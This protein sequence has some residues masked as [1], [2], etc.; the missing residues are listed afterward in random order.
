MSVV[1]NWYDFVLQQMA[2]ESYFEDV[3]LSDPIDIR[4][5]LTFGNNRQGFPFN[6]N[7]RFTDSQ[8]DD[9][10]D[11]FQIIHQ[12]SD[13]PNGTSFFDNTGLSAT[14]IFNKETNEYT[15]SIRSTEYQNK[16]LG[17]DFERDVL[18]GADRE[19]SNVG[20][21][22]AQLDSL[23]HYY[24]WLKESGKL[25]QG[26]VLNVTGYSL[27]GHLATVF[28]EVHS[29]EIKHTYL[30]NA[31]GRGE[32]RDPGSLNDGYTPSARLAVQIYHDVL[33]DPNAWTRYFKEGTFDFNE[34]LYQNARN[35][36]PVSTWTVTQQLGDGYIYANNRHLW[37]EKVASQLTSQLAIGSLDPAAN[38]KITDLYGHAAHND[39]EWVAT[40]GVRATE[41]R[42]QKI[43]IEDQQDFTGLGGFFGL[44]GDFGNTH[45]ITLVADS[46][47]VM[48]LLD[49][50]GLSTETATDRENAYQL[51]AA[52]SNQLG[53]GTL[54]LGDGKAEG[55][56]LEKIVESLYK[57]FKNETL[58]LRVDRGDR[59]FANIE[60]RNKFYEAIDTISA[61]A[62]TPLRYQFSSLAGTPADV[63]AAVAKT[64]NALATRYALKEGNPFIISGDDSL[65][66]SHNLNGELELYNPGS[67]TGT[68][69]DEYINERARFLERKLYYNLGDAR[70]NLMAGAPQRDDQ[71][72]R[73]DNEDI[74]WKDS[75]SGITINRGT[76]GSSRYVLF[77]SDQPDSLTGGARDDYLF[78]GAGND[79]LHGGQGD[80][81][82][83]GGSGFDIYGFHPGDGNDTLL[84]QDGKG[85]LRYGPSG[86]E[87]TLV[88][89][90]RNSSDPEGQY[91]SADGLTSYVINSTNL[92][93]TTPDGG[94]ITVR[95]FDR[96]KTDLG[97]H[98]FDVPA[99]AIGSVLEGT[100]GNNTTSSSGD[101]TPYEPG[102]NQ[103]NDSVG[104]LIASADTAAIDGLG[105][106]DTLIGNNLPGDRLNGGDGHDIIVDGDQPSGPGGKLYG[107]AGN[108]ILFANG[109]DDYIDGGA[110]NDFAT[111]NAGS[112]L[113]LGDRGADWLDG[114]DG[115]DAQE[116]GNDNDHLL[117]GAGDDLLQGEGGDDT[118]Y[119]DTDF[120]AIFLTR[121][122]GVIGV[123]SS[124]DPNFSGIFPLLRDVTPSAAGDDVLDGGAGNDQLYAGAGDDV[125][126]GGADND[127]LEGEGG[128]D[129]LLG[130]A[131]EDILW[132]DADPDT[133]VTD[134]AISITAGYYRYYTRERNVG[135]DGN[136]TLAGGGGNDRLFGGGGDDTY[137]FG[138]GDGQ[139]IIL[140]ATG[141][142][143]LR[144]DVGS[145]DVTLSPSGADLI[146]S[147]NGTSDSVTLRNWFGAS[148]NRIESL[149][150]A[151]GTMW[152][153]SVVERLTRTKPINGPGPVADD[154][155]D[156]TTYAA[157]LGADLTNGFAI[158]VDDAGGTDALQFNRLFLGSTPAGPL[159]VT[160]KLQSVV[161][162]GSDLLINLLLQPPSGSTISGSVRIENYSGAGEIESI[163]IADQQLLSLHSAAVT[164]G[165]YLQTNQVSP[166]Y[167]RFDPNQSYAGIRAEIVSGTD[168]D[169][170]ASRYGLTSTA[171]D[172]HSLGSLGPF[173][174][175]ILYG[176]SGNDVLVGADASDT[177]VGG[178]G[179][180]ILQGGRGSDNYYVDLAEQDVVFDDNLGNSQVSLDALYLPTGV[181]LSD[182]TFSRTGDDLL[183][184][185]LRIERY[186]DRDFA[187]LGFDDYPFQIERLVGDGWQIADLPNYLQSLG[188]Y[189][190]I[191]GAEAGDT[192]RGDNLNNTIDGGGGDDTILGGK[193]SDRLS[194]GTG[195]DTLYGEAIYRGTASSNNDVLDG[196]EGDDY[197]E[198]DERDDTLLGGAGDDVL[199]GDVVLNGNP[200][201]FGTPGRDVLVGGRGNDF[202]YGQQDGDIYR[203]E[204]GDGADVLFDSGINRWDNRSGNSS[205]AVTGD[206]ISELTS[207]IDALAD[208]SDGRYVSQEWYGFALEYDLDELLPRSILDGLF[209]QLPADLKENGQI[210]GVS[211]GEALA[212]LSELRDWLIRDQEDVVEFGAGISIED[213]VVASTFDGLQI[214][215]AEGD[216]VTIEDAE[217][218]GNLGIERFR[219]SDGTTLALDDVL[220][221]V[222]TPVSI[223]G[224]EGDDEL[225]GNEA[226]NVLEGR[227]GDDILY[228]RSGD[229]I[230][231]GGTGTAIGD[232]LLGEEGSDV[233]LFNR[234]DIISNTDILAQYNV[235]N[236]S[237]FNP[238]PM[239]TDTDIDT[240][241]FGA[242][243]RPEDIDAVLGFADYPDGSLFAT[244]VLTLHG[245]HQSIL[246]DWLY[247]DAVTGNSNDFRI[248]R[249]QF[250]GNGDDRV[251][252]L[253]GLVVARSSAL[254]AANENNPV[255]L[256]TPDALS[257][258]DI[259]ATAGF[260]GGDYARNYAVTGDVFTPPVSPN[261]APILAMPLSDQTANEDSAFVFHVPA[262]TFTDEDS[263]DSLTYAATRA[264]GSALPSWLMFEAATRTFSGTPANDNVG[265]VDIRV[266]AADT[267]NASIADV[268]ALTIANT[269]D[270]PALANS[271]ADQ[272]ATQDATFSFTV[273]A[274]TFADI[275]AG[276]TLAYSA[277]LN[278]GSVLPPWLSFDAAT[279]TFSG[280]PAN[281]D[282]GS[283]GVRVTATDSANA[284]VFDDFNLTILNVNDAPTVAVPLVDQSVDQYGA[285]T[286]QLP[287]NTFSDPDAGD[288]LS[289]GA[290]RADGSSLPTWLAFDP[291]TQTFSG[292]PTHADIG[293]LGVRVT[294]TDQ[295]GLAASSVFTLTVI[296]TTP[297]NV[298]GGANNDVLTG[299]DGGDY[300]QGLSG[301]D[302][303]DG[304]AGNDLIVGGTGI[305][306][307][308]GGDGDDIIVI[309][310]TDTAY[311]TVSGGLGTDTAL[312]STGG[313]TFRFANF[314]GVN[315]V[316]VIDGVA[317]SDII[318]GTG[319]NDLLDFSGTALLNI[320]KIDAGAGNDTV[321]GSSGNDVISGGAGIDTLRGGDGNDIFSIEGADTAYDTVNG[322]L[323]TDVVLGG[324]G[325]DTFRF[326]NFS[327]DNTVETID[328]GAGANIV[329]GTANNDVL[330]FSAT[331]LAN[332]TRIDAGSGND[333]VTGS[334]GDDVIVGG[335]G[336]DTL[337]GGDGDDTFLIEGTDT[338]YDTVNGGL[339][340]DTVLGSAFDDTFRFA[341]FSGANTVEIIDGGAGTNLVAGT[342][343]NDVLDFSATTL[344]N[345][346]KIDAGAGNDT[347]IGSAGD[348]LIV[349]GAGIDTLKG[350]DGNDIFSIE[351]SDTAYDTVSG[352]PGIDT[353][354]GSSGDDIFRFN[355]F[356][357]DNTTE[358]IDGGAGTNLVAGTANNDVLDFGA[359]TL[360]H[361][362][363]IDA[364]AGND[365]VTGSTGNDFI[366]GG[367]G[368]DTL[369]GGD[370]DDL[371][372]IEGTDAAYDTISGG[373]GSDTILGG[374]G[375]DTFRF[376][377]FSGA[378]TVEIIDGGAGTN[379]VAGTANNDVLDFSSTSLLGISKID[380]GAGNDTV[381]GSA[382]NDV[383][384]GGTG[385]DT[386]RGGDGDDAFIIEGA[387]AAY[388]T[389]SGGS[390]AD[391][392]LG[393]TG[394]DT[395]RFNN[396]SGANTV[397]I[398]D[399]AAGA[400]VVAGTANNDILD[401]SATT[402]RSIANI[403]AGAGNDA[404]TGSSGND[405]IFGGAGIDT[406]RGGNG[407]DMLDG[408]VGNDTL[409]GGP[410]N[411]TYIFNSGY[412]N[413]SITD[414]DAT[415]GNQDTVAF[416]VNPLD[417]VF[418]RSGNNLQMKLHGGT[419]SLTV[420]AWYGGTSN[421]T[422]ILRAQDS[423]TL[424]NT[425]VDQL[426]Q[427]MA[428][429]SADHGGIT[430]DQAIDQNPNE[431]QAVLAAYWQAA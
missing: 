351:G 93:I 344:L 109:G 8:A 168:G 79:F 266:I 268:F 405:V 256:F 377:N 416:G 61:L 231:V 155:T 67:R 64:P 338:A 284:S 133:A 361:I 295:G 209:A 110:D 195:N 372:S 183:L 106:H 41:D 384:S 306:T 251:F 52:A 123:L 210:D 108:D 48:R 205:F 102:G 236:I 128:D 258:F 126:L 302:T 178:T 425:Q 354:L 23:E 150:F 35:T 254:E 147:I 82:L 190:P 426:I 187:E 242:D 24:A 7:T 333:T 203:F 292:R 200:G 307:L 107:E 365:T 182:L 18:G 202:L 418:T 282:V 294:A 423:S 56:S 417:V 175:T 401:F 404:V 105:G 62:L 311:D 276:D 337:K 40:L 324:A 267:T 148:T 327:G 65:Y 415:G 237:D 136:D 180:D 352:G 111:G 43:F 12:L 342:G 14:L 422:E 169:D 227:Q 146:V 353:V 389:V 50:L 206:T 320:G 331:I 296:N 188:L 386:L 255:S 185:N 336:I 410:G 241:S 319:N 186:F 36:P 280:T 215:Y 11:R 249:L 264:D 277:S 216:S 194:G 38:A 69:T 73:F 70:Y 369:R 98:L 228:G 137:V 191:T 91:K 142:D 114:N 196:G 149:Q 134:A 345:I 239:G 84:D 46:L 29:A 240:I 161:A 160:P 34:P 411:D 397:E 330:D 157:Y 286:Y 30:F 204:R 54:F 406:L 245:T 20:F 272:A 179:N 92:I 21:A 368:I 94:T 53:T 326:A 124:S 118:L 392:V 113:L 381:T 390:G 234:A 95:N 184:G 55:D 57:L 3:D 2:A 218:N 427:A 290:T 37:A 400:N 192:L 104:D 141:T 230:L 287:A 220:A 318:A 403:D 47:A 66:A 414:N 170:T 363:K 223:I 39:G 257:V 201:P 71:A 224:T 262:G 310:G 313:D 72:T 341:N 321:I 383:I 143:T 298:T 28:T 31:A 76:T 394:D 316:E 356:S 317:G 355:N 172:Y 219:F 347:V 374:T 402:L 250:L 322:G 339:G 412:G 13:N 387:D 10:L 129:W 350:G 171:F 1:Q 334:A 156:P 259:T 174:Q 420:N 346:T 315:T 348:D 139:D 265:T 103:H 193:G 197:L 304:G 312:G 58:S 189:P 263:G 177:L 428:Q 49:Q 212:T 51:L 413:D 16:R 244:L 303:V 340:I 232:Y 385:I 308:R 140:D 121:Y 274:N 419:D 396:F 281:A 80:D 27:G 85:L 379:I 367:A 176:N 421:Q 248:E 131:G 99:D 229:D 288:S 26:A 78:G 235:D 163:S 279:K 335:A 269:N 167:V 362:G 145:S 213:L 382:G 260:A 407:D 233:Y 278:D 409:T 119:G 159:Y 165:V 97:I 25:P 100:A 173:A 408:G 359:T 360:V 63:L 273:P 349:G 125:L 122:T 357:G 83:E 297:N 375:D 376:N 89:G 253:K 5:A 226:D 77:G 152:D 151:D 217:G 301:N 305:D 138:R 90:L 88:L 328:G 299:T 33:L 181:A 81:Y 283:L 19:I 22:F 132:G 198:G 270:A 289:Y 44:P 366:V 86:E 243:I 399:G 371:F 424:L 246:I 261:H 199:Y 116:G 300:L 68:L 153:Q 101:A 166:L 154:S 87:Q 207:D 130:G 120:G 431:V 343:N 252:D 96:N 59:G 17:G 395:F 380:A 373:L 323:G 135:A 6:G 112:D 271:I 214:I 117:G 398:I 358:V 293:N 364:G 211:R 429:F 275:D 4:R 285:F 9:F 391:T 247:S 314:S 325:D 158:T 162:D 291:A 15:L 388:D 238:D 74:V 378:N 60:N 222:Q 45:S 127:T 225:R 309:E 32:I 393:G 164:P 332:I 115:N 75:T 221:L 144:L 42:R 370:G 208:F 430:W 329:A